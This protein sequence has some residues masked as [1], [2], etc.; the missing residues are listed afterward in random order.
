[1]VAEDGISENENA[2]VFFTSK[3][4]FTWDFNWI[5]IDLK[6]YAFLIICN[7]NSIL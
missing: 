6:N 1:M 7:C 3:F 4:S 2:I 5:A